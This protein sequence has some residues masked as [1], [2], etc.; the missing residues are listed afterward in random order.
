MIR[1]TSVTAA[2]CLTLVLA[3]LAAAQVP[4]FDGGQPALTGRDRITLPSRPLLAQTYAAVPGSDPAVQAC[5]T[6]DTPAVPE[7]DDS[8]WRWRLRAYH[9]LDCVLT[10]IDP[11]LRAPHDRPADGVNGDA[12]RLSRE[13]AERI[14]ALTWWA[15]DAAARIA[16]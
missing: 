15:R 10:L 3:P 16:Q 1:I 8:R 9:Y 12:V 6:G 5:R 14:R 11:A 4:Q 13:D 7:P 2:C